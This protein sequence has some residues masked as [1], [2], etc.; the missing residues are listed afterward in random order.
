MPADTAGDVKPGY[1]RT[2]R[3]SIDVD[4]TLPIVRGDGG[5]DQLLRKLQAKLAEC[6][7]VGRIRLDFGGIA[8]V[9]SGVVPAVV[10]GLA[11][12]DLFRQRLELHGI[13]SE[14]QRIV[15]LLIE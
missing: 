13:G 10:T 11:G 3:R 4:S 5:F 6:F 2:H 7:S 1:R 8:M 14:S 9:K 15:L 12:V